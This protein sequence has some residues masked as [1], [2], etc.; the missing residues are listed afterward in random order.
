MDFQREI[1]KQ[2][3]ENTNLKEVNL[4][5]PP[6]GLGDYAFPCFS[7]SKI[8]KKN[9]ARIAQELARKIKTGTF[10]KKVEVKGAY[11]NFFVNKTIIAEDILKKITKDKEEF[12]AK[13]GKKQ[14]ILVEHT[15]INPNASPHIGRARNAFIGDF[16]V[17]LLKFQGYKVETH[18]FI[19]D[20]G[21]QIAMLVFG[22]KD[23]KNI[24]FDKLL[25]LYIETNKKIE[26]NLELEKKVFELLRKLEQGDEKVKREFKDIVD[27]CVKGQIKILS[28]LGIKYD[29]FDYESDY[30][31]T[32]KTDKVLKEL[33]K[34]GKLFLDNE[35]RYILDQKE[36]NL[37][38][39]SPVLVLTRANKTSL[40]PLRDIAYHIDKKKDKSILVLGEDQKL[41]FEQI[42]SVLTLLKKPS[43][44]P[45]FYSFVLLKTGKMSTRKGNLVL[46]E[47]FMKEALQK[48]RREI[49]K[50]H[51]RI[52]E[53]DAKKIAYGAI[54]YSILK[55]APE[56]NVTFSWKALQFEGDTGPYLQYACARINSI[57]RK[58]GKKLDTKV[59]FSL[60]K[61]EEEINLIK[62]LSSFDNI[63][64]E[65][66][67]TSK[68][69]IIANYLYNLA[70]EFSNFYIKCPVLKAEENLRKARLLLA[71]S[72]RQ[73]LEN[74]LGILGIEVLEKM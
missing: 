20:V 5:I 61:T 54:K 23:K 18:Y 44:K 10:I 51:H 70:Q 37:P 42:K 7:L 39:E 58:Y 36:F 4:E 24:T 71:S 32:G 41:Y 67:R 65:A 53:K 57:L 72:V 48:A 27:I 3:K 40:Y 38:M 17:R 31:W 62:I 68:P 66:E 15:S 52:N 22:A 46:L 55:V 25:K 16:I 8:H 69:N 43:P 13:K 9:P 11:L 21:K 30:L 73:V 35:K 74:G 45:I 14:K 63:I 47:D 64:E 12:G 2:I 29:K 59:D 6:K 50:R 56:R 19:N 33:E 60:L 49:K 26:E 28:E 34:T 1:I